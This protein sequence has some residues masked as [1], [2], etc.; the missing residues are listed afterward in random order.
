MFVS[1]INN[2]NNK[3]SE[4]IS[5]GHSFR[6]SICIKGEDGQKDIFVNPY[7][8]EK[9]YGN[10]NSKLVS[11]F[12]SKYFDDLWKSLGLKRRVNSSHLLNSTAKEMVNDLHELDSDYRHFNY[13]R[14]VYKRG[15]LGFIATGLDVP[16]LENIKGAKQVGIAK[17]DSYYTDGHYR[18][19]YARTMA[20]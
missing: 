18:N 19:D 13:V 6:V 10:L 17:A 12:N 3:P 14:S 16:I 5:F 1:A 15:H 2:F 8:E 11:F 7:S 4:K 20:K 9:L